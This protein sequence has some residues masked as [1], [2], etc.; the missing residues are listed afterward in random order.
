MNKKNNKKYYIS[1]EEFYL[2]M[3]AWK[4]ACEEAEQAG[5]LR[6]RIT[7]S[8]GSKIMMIATRLSF[9][10][11]FINYPFR[12]E[13]VGDAIENC[14]LYIHNF[15]PDKSEKNPFGYFSMISYWAFVRR[16]KREKW[17]FFKKAKFVQNMG[18]DPDI[19]LA[20][21]QDHDLGVEY[22]NTYVD[23]LKTFYDVDLEIEESKKRAKNKKVKKK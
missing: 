10:P 7:E 4:K 20:N 16:I 1:K 22:S 23:F 2:E 21:I 8:I 17:E 5:D 19:D 12:E 14:I 13:M 15:N 18:I 11:R 3:C 9:M 6:P